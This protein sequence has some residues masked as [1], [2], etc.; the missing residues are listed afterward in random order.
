MTGEPYRPGGDPA[1]DPWWYVPEHARVRYDL[2]CRNIPNALRL[3]AQRHPDLEALVAEDGRRSF[4]ELDRDMIAAVRAVQALGVRPGDRVGIWAPNS[5]WWVVA[6]LGILG[7]GAV[8]VPVNTR[9][10][11]EEAA[12]VLRK[13]GARALFLVSDFLDA[14]YTGMVRGA[15]PSLPVLEAGNSVV[16]SGAAAPGQLSWDDFLRGGAAVAEAD[17]VAAVDAVMPEMLSDI[18]FTSGTTGHPK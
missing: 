6:A 1:V 9:F 17:A 18:M 7:A 3:T 11:G 2:K 5:G 4:A 14:D 16:L 13:S 12:Y 15:D 8:L 10:K